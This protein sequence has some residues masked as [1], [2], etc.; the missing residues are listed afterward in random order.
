MA[1]AIGAKPANKDVHLGS[2]QPPDPSAANPAASSAMP[3]AVVEGAGQLKAGQPAPVNAANGKKP[4]AK[5]RC[6]GHY[7]IGK[8]IGEGTF[9]KVKAGTHNVTG[10]KV[11]SA[12]CDVVVVVVS[13]AHLQQSL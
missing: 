1:S 12:N 3:P 9:G 4:V 8:N 13:R 7:M 10:E 6:I 5:S 2:T 11:R